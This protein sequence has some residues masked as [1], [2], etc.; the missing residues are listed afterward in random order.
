LEDAMHVLARPIIRPQTETEGASRP[1]NRWLVLGI[2]LTAVFMQLL[3]TTITMV[4][5]GPL[6]TV[7]CGG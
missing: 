2:I 3:D 6:E 1:R 5:R 4:I 7:C